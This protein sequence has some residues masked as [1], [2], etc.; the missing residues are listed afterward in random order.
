MCKSKEKR[1][2]R[3]RAAGGGQLPGSSRRHGDAGLILLCHLLA[4]RDG[5]GYEEFVEAEAPQ[6]LSRTLN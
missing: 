4:R 6:R 2:R 1:R 3:R 5:D